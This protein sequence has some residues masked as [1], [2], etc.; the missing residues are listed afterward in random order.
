MLAL[1][2][3]APQAVCDLQLTRVPSHDLVCTLS[4][5]HGIVLCAAL[6]LPHSSPPYGNVLSFSV[7]FRRVSKVCYFLLFNY[8]LGFLLAS[9]LGAGV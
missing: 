9:G 7:Q 1:C 8:L 4:C 3:L 5:E 6:S 2:Y